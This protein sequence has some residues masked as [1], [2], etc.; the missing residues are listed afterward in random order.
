MKQQLNTKSMQAKLIRIFLELGSLLEYN[1][2]EFLL[3]EKVGL[4]A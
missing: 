2:A 4:V 3:K 1:Y